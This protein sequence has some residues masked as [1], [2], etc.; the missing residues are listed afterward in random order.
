MHIFEISGDWQSAIGRTGCS[1]KFT[2][3]FLG[4]GGAVSDVIDHDPLRLK[5]ALMTK[6][7]RCLSSIF[8][9]T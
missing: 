9:G 3:V 6:L 1:L 5:V 7:S 2:A 4:T 8:S